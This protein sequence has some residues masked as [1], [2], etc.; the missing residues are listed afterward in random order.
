MVTMAIVPWQ[1]GSL[2]G[3]AKSQI[4]SRESGREAHK[5][6]GKKKRLHRFG[7][8]WS[9]RGRL[10]PAVVILWSAVVDLLFSS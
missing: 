9:S 2:I 1:G 8:L 10:W 5:F 3:I 6:S 7:R 4:E